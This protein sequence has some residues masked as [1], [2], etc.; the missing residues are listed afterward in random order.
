MA[1]AVGD[2]LATYKARRDFKKTP[3]P[4]A[5]RARSKGNSFVIQKHAARRTHFDFRLEHDGVLKSWAVTRGPS[6]D[7]SQKRL[8]VMTEDHPLEY[9]KFEGVIPKGEYGGGPVMIWDRGTWEPIGDPDQ[10]LAKGDLKFRLHGDRLNGDYVLVRMNPRKGEKR[11]NWLLIKK[12]DGYAGDG[13][14]PT[15]KFETSVKS[16]RTM[17]QIEHGDSAVWSS[18]AKAQK[19]TPKLK[20]KAGASAGTA[21]RRRSRAA[22]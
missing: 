11:E 16:G 7:P 4:A 3:E 19:K 5:K 14:E 20:P 21:K 1:R 13:N 10:G 15:E 9:G 12:R 6:L 2:P 17:D 18:K 22:R 8:A